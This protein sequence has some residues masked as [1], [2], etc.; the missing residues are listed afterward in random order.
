M[1]INS[2]KTSSGAASETAI[3]RQFISDGNRSLC[4]KSNICC[5]AFCS[6]VLALWADESSKNWC[7]LPHQSE[8]CMKG[9]CRSW[10]NPFFHSIDLTLLCQRGCESTNKTAA[11]CRPGPTATFGVA[12]QKARW[13]LKW[14]A[15]LAMKLLLSLPAAVTCHCSVPWSRC[16]FVC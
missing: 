16:P 10:N 7:I 15:C 9:F 2:F 3:I 12:V 1:A 8:W 4:Y 13:W 6:P 11:D 14:C 5:R